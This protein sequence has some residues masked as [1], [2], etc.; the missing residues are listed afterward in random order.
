MIN[1]TILK[2]GVCSYQILKTGS[3]KVL[4][5]ESWLPET[6]RW[7]LQRI[8]KF[9]FWTVWTLDGFGLRRMRCVR[10]NQ[11]S[12]AKLLLHPI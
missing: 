6:V 5:R 12:D 7:F 10:I 2:K 9:L 3:F 4:K 8:W 1:K 11:L